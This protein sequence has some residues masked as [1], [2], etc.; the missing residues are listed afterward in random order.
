MI[1]FHLIKVQVKQKM[2][3]KEGKTR[4]EMKQRALVGGIFILS[5]FQFNSPLRLPEY[6]RTGA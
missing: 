4:S 2:S 5:H 3:E 6:F 1:L